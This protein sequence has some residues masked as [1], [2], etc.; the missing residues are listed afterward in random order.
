MG[1]H[2]IR[3]LQLG[4]VSIVA[5]CETHNDSEFH[6]YYPEGLLLYV[7]YGTLV[8]NQQGKDWRVTK[9]N[10]VLIRKFTEATLRKTW[11]AQEGEARTYGFLLGNDFTRMAFGGD[12]APPMA[13][14]DGAPI[15]SARATATLVQVV[16]ALKNHFEGQTS[17][18][19][20]HLRELIASAMQ[21]L[22]TISPGVAALLHC[23]CS[24]I[25][26]DIKMLMERN[27]LLNISVKELAEKSGRSLS[28][29]NREFKRI[30]KTT[31]HRWKMQQRLFHARNLM[32]LYGK[33][34]IEVYLES[35]FEDL[36]HFSRAFKRQF[37]MPPSDYHAWI[38][39]NVD[40]AEEP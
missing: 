1:K 10:F 24:Q 28:T 29:F 16:T 20:D 37:G 33:R 23:D 7:D 12:K 40:F 39:E 2:Y 3:S 34:P 11:T 15:F 13:Q 25:R 21:S 4:D 38:S 30:F 8:V 18:D 27:Y 32:Q 22:V 36:S 17:V 9:G 35:G 14:P 5:S 19:K 31:P 26:T 6:I